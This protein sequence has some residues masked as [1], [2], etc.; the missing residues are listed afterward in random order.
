MADSGNNASLAPRR[1]PGRPRVRID[2]AALYELAKIHCT[3]PEMAAVLRVDERTIRRRHARLVQKGKEEGK[4]SLRRMQFKAAE[5]GN[6][7]MMI[8]LGKQ[9]LGQTDRQEVGG[10]NGAPLLETITVRLVKAGGG[11][12][13]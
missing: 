13:D 4:A 12:P 7:T 11:A 10:P 1:K 5:G 8:W 3:Y 9:Q 6:V 2:E